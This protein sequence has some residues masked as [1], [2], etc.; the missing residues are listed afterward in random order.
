MK[1]RWVLVLFFGMLLAGPASA[2][3]LITIDESGVGSLKTMT[4]AVTPLVG[5]L[6][7]D[8]DGHPTLIYTPPPNMVHLTDGDLYLHEGSL[9]NPFSDVV[10]FHTGT[11]CFYSDGQENGELQAQLGDVGIP[12]HLLSN[13]VNVLEVGSEGANGAVYRPQMGQPGFDPTQTIIVDVI[14]DTPEPSSIILM[15]S[16][17]V[18]GLVGYMRSERIRRK[19]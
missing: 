18:I 13:Q 7:V 3:T 11:I 14:S 5:V 16:G 4:G 8:A 17:G 6:G 10:R 15:A 12:V 2:S 19:K 9:S 1:I